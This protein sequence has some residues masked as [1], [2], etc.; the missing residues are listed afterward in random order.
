MVCL[1]R[2]VDG[3]DMA[4]RI[5]VGMRVSATSSPLFRSISRKSTLTKFHRIVE[6]GTRDQAQ[7]AIA[8]LSNRDLMG[9]LV[10]VREVWTRSL[11]SSLTYVY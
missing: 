6:Y 11:P 7:N 1:G 5:F 9:R 3:T 8:T 2:W 4:V 10:Y